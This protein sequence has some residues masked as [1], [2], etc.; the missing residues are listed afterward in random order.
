MG[1]DAFIYGTVYEE[2]E[3][4]QDLSAFWE[5][6]DRLFGRLVQGRPP[7]YVDL[8]GPWRK[9]GDQVEVDQEEWTTV[10]IDAPMG[11]YYSPDYPG[12][13]FAYYATTC[14]WLESAFPV[15]E[16]NVWYGGDQRVGFD[17]ATDSFLASRMGRYV[18][19]G[20]LDTDSPAVPLRDWWPVAWELARTS[21]Q[22]GP[23]PLEASRYLKEPTVTPGHLRSLFAAEDPLIRCRAIWAFFYEHLPNDRLRQLLTSL[24]WGHHYYMMPRLSSCALAI[25]L[26][27]QSL[28]TLDPLKQ[29]APVQTF[30]QEHADE[31]NDLLQERIINCGFAHPIDWEGLKPV[32]TH[33]R[34]GVR[35]L[36]QALVQELEGLD[37]LEGKPGYKVPAV[38]GR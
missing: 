6:R 3:R 13:D 20:H 28:E 1:V 11:R 14:R 7:S 8:T 27:G 37:M 5:D 31:A 10:E 33:E 17:L 19:F 23:V 2:P 34:E 32:L 4:E 36:G 21:G 9:D 12:G 38:E 24:F 15:D 16:V 35:R 29:E 22:F 18:S 30:L 25:S 26:A